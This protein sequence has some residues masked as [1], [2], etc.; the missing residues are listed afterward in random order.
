VGAGVR[1]GD[2]ACAKRSTRRSRRSSP[3]GTYDSITANYF[4]SSIYGG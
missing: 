4:A 1:K 2:D 3:D